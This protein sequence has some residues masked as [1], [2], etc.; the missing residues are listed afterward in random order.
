MA[1]GNVIRMPKRRGRPRGNAEALAEAAFQAFERDT[2]RRRPITPTI[3]S[4]GQLRVLQ[5][6]LQT[7]ACEIDR[8]RSG[9]GGIVDR[10]G[11]EEA[12]K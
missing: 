5:A 3:Q 4:G 6:L 9:L 8:K 1:K 12:S 11:K 7:L 2:G 10:I